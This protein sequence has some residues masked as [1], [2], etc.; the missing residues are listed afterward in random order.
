LARLL[1]CLVLTV[2]GFIAGARTCPTPESG[3][4]IL[5]SMVTGH[6]VLMIEANDGAVSH[7]VAR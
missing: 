3:Q 2:I 7:A 4:V 6:I 1:V 5:A